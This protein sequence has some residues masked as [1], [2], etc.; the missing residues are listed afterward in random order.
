[1]KFF[2]LLL[3]VVIAGVVFTGCA[4]KEIVDIKPYQSKYADDK[5]NKSLNLVSVNDKRKTDIIATLKEGDKVIGEYKSSANLESWFK[6]ALNKDLS[7]AGITN[8]ADSKVILD[9][10]ILKFDTLYDRNKGIKNLT[11]RVEIELVFKNEN[12]VYKKF[13]KHTYNKFKGSISDAKG[14]EKFAYDNLSDSV[15]NSIKASVMSLGDD[16]K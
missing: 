7:K 8:T 6:D 3:L 2:K 14:F 13:I 11:G 10:N 5:T 4:V 9:I 16:I 12:K 1:M 15:I